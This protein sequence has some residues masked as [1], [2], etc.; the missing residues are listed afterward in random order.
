MLLAR[1]DVEGTRPQER[2][3]LSVCQ[4]QFNLNLI[5]RRHFHVCW[6]FIHVSFKISTK[7]LKF[8]RWAI[9]SSAGCCVACMGSWRH[10]RH[11]PVC[12]NTFKSSK[13]CETDYIL[14]FSNST[15]LLSFWK[16][17]FLD[18]SANPFENSPRRKVSDGEINDVSTNAGNGTPSCIL[19]RLQTLFF[20]IIFLNFEIIN[21]FSISTFVFFN[22]STL[23]CH[24]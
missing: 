22:I 5:S 23:S 24:E 1:S 10:H 20:I 3:R 6:I 9:K 17:N 16:F 19:L 7:T 2:L 15:K 14:H 11:P 13:L 12:E 18:V 8:S 21:L 4:N